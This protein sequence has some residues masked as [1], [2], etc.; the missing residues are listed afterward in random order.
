MDYEH[1][2]RVKFLLIY[3]II[4][5]TKYRRKCL[6]SLQILETIKEISLVSDFEIIT[7]EFEADHLH[8]MIRSTPKQSTL[9]LIRR[10]KSMSTIRS[11][12]KFPEIL[13]QF[14]WKE[15]TLWSDSYFVCTVGNASIS[16]VEKYINEQG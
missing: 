14:Y 12:K 7:Q 16:T 4:L 11:W 2:N 10:I 5:V 6:T 3:H 1:M 9:S 15:K 13:R 8:L